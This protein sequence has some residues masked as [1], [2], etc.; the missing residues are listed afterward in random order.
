MTSL[1]DDIAALIAARGPITFAAFMQ[2]ALY[3]PRGYYGSGVVRTGWQGDFV[4]SPEIDPAYGELWAR[5]FRSTWDAC[6]R[7]PEFAIV[8]I[9]AGEG[10]FAAS[11]L[12]SVEEPFASALSYSIVER[13]APVAERQRALIGDD[14]RVKWA[15]WIDELDRAATG[16]VFANEVLDNLPV[17]VVRGTDRGVE[18]L[19]VH[20]DDGRFTFTPAPLSSDEVSSYL[21]RHGIHPAPGQT[22][23]VGIAAEQM[24]RRLAAKIERGAI[25]LVDYG[26]TSEG[27]AAR[28]AGTLVSYSKGA[29][30]DDVLSDVGS[31]D[32][33]A[34][35][36]WSAATATLAD[37]GFEVRGPLK[38]RAVLHELGSRALDEELRR[39]HREAVLRGA[40]AEALSTLSRR[41]ALGALTDEGGLGG[42]DVVIAT[43]GCAPSRAVSAQKARP[44]PGLF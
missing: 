13:A 38:Q 16:C 10:A 17:H 42:L 21:L 3:D 6:G 26:D 12:S 22:F 31:K 35:V 34:H 25:V 27:L 28:P 44:E 1:A 19:H 23:E 15:T 14:A 9:G 8:E 32:I 20:L 36:N 18:E 30:N 33:T 40:G 29:V 4:T 43:R 41:Q 5:A 24:L 2:L 39:L 7:P 37:E 11:V